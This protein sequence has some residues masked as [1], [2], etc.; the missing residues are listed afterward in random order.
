MTD[1]I[2]L[3]KRAHGA[4]NPAVVA[5]GGIVTGREL[6]QRAAAGLEWLVDIG[7][8]EG[9]AVPALLD[10]NADSLALVAAGA[11]GRRPLAPLGPRL[12]VRELTACVDRLDAPVLVCQPEFEP[13]AAEVA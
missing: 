1:W 5:A 3:L 9:G 2:T 11:A 7:T 10:T 12:T 4:E 6:L 8:P 13:L